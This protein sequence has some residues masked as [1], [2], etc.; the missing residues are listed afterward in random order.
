MIV[1]VVFTICIPAFAQEAAP[2]Q[3][4]DQPAA[5]GTAPA[6]TGTNPNF[7]SVTAL[8]VEYHVPQW[9]AF[10]FWLLRA[11]IMSFAILLGTKFLS[12]VAD[13]AL[14]FAGFFVWVIGL[15]ALA[16][17]F[18]GPFTPCFIGFVIGI[19]GY[20]AV[21]EQISTIEC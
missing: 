3:T 19:A 9:A 11:A 7:V 15:C 17:C 10:V 18:Y 1:L 13:T 14:P 8:G 12:I 20:Q 16:W 21:A 6:Q 4:G 5:T 2:A